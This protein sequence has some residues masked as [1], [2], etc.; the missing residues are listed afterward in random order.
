MAYNTECANVA[1]VKVE[2]LGV[3]RWRMGMIDSASGAFKEKLKN[4]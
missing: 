4:W 3:G 2:N 1:E